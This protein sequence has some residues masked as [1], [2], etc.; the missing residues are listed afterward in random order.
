MPKPRITLLQLIVGL[1]VFSA[2]VAFGNALYAAYTVQKEQLVATTLEGNRAYAVKLAEV[3]D[4]YIGAIQRQ[5]TV[6]ARRI[7]TMMDAPA[8]MQDEVLRLAQQSDGIISAAVLDP[9]GEVVAFA[10]LLPGAESRVGTQARIDLGSAAQERNVTPPYL[11]DQGLWTVALTEPIRSAQS[12]YLGLVGAAIYLQQDTELDK[13]LQEHFYRDGSYVYVVGADG[14]IL[15]HYDPKRIGTP[16]RENRVV[17]ALMRGESG[18]MPVT[19]TMG[20]DMLAG[21][22]PMSQGGW[23]VVVQRPVSDTLAPLSGLMD[24]IFQY[25]IPAALVMLLMVTAMGYWIARPL[26]TLARAMTSGDSGKARPLIQSVPANY[27]EAQQLR[28]A[29]DV[30]LAQH[31]R[32]IGTLNAKTMTDPMTGLLNRRGVDDALSRL[33][34]TRQPFSALA[35]DLDRF[36]QVNDTFGHAAGDQVLIALADIMRAGVRDVDACCRVGGEEFLVLMPGAS[37]D[38]ALRVAERIRYVT[39]RHRMPGQVG[40]VT[41][42]IGVARWPDHGEETGQVL[43]RADQA[44][45]QAK[46]SGRNQAVLWGAQRA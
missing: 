44:L 40:H 8:A 10:S 7:A 12:K 23:G 33:Q 14:T 15:Y 29:V 19:N 20:V 30:T 6:G 21:Y 27:F 31:E 17:Q 32:Q 34:A 46:T 5:L 41:V 42:S 16:E 2:A 3:V 28:T 35:L 37:P 45:Y 4:L 18:A 11:S 26:A 38:A 24:R 36:K 39:E 43:E 22:A 25:S 13:L 9:T 1:S